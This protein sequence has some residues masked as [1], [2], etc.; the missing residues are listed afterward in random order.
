MKENKYDNPAFFNQYSQM[1]RSVKGLQGAGEWHILQ[2]MLPAIEDKRVLDLG[3]GFGW[4]CQYA[5]EQGAKSVLG[6]DLSEKMLDTAKQKNQ[7]SFVEY[8]Q[9]AIEDFD[10]LAESFDV[11]LSSLAFHYLESFDDVCLKVNKCLSVGGTFVFSVE[12]PVFTAYGSQDWFYNENG[13][14]IHWPVDNYYNE[15]IR[16]AN[17]LGQEVIK[18]HKTLTT[19]VHALL[20]SGFEITALVEPE[21]DEIS[22]KTIPGMQDE[23]RRPIFLIISALKK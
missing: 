20:K 2:K 13:E 11:V 21:P 10:F 12:H 15:G 4:H 18:Y 6:I 16:K 17:F 23:L 5:A 9:M 7:F 22:L 3:C 8:Q 1:M 19:Y 14:P